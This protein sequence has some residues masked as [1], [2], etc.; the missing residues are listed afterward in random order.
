MFSTS[1]L[2]QPQISKNF[3]RLPSFDWVTSHPLKK[4]ST[5]AKDKN[6]KSGV[7]TPSFLKSLLLQSLLQIVLEWV[8]GTKTPFFRGYLEH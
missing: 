8:L 1:L 6:K 2:I 4:N 7:K 3:L 5:F